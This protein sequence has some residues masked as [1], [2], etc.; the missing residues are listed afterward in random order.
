MSPAELFMGRTLRSHLHILKPNL[1]QTVK[2]KLEQ[3]KLSH[4]KRAV[5]RSFVEGEKVFARNY[6]SI[7]KK[8]LHGIVISVAQRSLKVRLTSGLVIHHHFDQI[9]KR[10]LDEIPEDKELVTDSDAYTY[11]P[12]SNDKS[13][14]ISSQS[15]S[16]DPPATEQLPQNRRCPLRTRKAPDCLHL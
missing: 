7:G 12:V 3:Q 6:A 8:W 11:F 1:S 14:T 13:E 5:D 4:D 10:S 15:G 9:R 16:P 2:N